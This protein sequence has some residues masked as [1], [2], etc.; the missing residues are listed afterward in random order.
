ML[1]DI[2]HVKAF[3]NH[4]LPQHRKLM[5]NR[6]IG[7]DLARAYAILGMFL[8]NF[9]TVFGSHTNHLGLSGF[10]NLFNGNSSSLFVMLAGMGVS[11]M[12]NRNN[13]ALEDR[14]RIRGV[15]TR[16]SLF[17]IALGLA[18]FV[19]WPA[20]ILHFYGGYMHIAVLFI[21]LPKKYLL[22]ASLFAIVIFHVLL[23]VIPYEAGWNFDTFVY[24]DFWTISGFLRNTFYNGWNPIFPWVA[25][26]FLG[27]YLGKMKWADDK[28][29]MKVFLIG[30]AVY[31]IVSIIQYYAP[32]ITNDK[33]LLLYLTADYIP[34]FLPFMLG[35]A[36]FG[37]MIISIFVVVGR[38]F[39]ET[40]LAK[41]LAYTGQMTLTHYITHLTLGFFMLS[42]ITGRT[43]RY[44]MLADTPTS[45]II[46]LTFGMTYFL[47]SCMFSYYWAKKFKKGPLEMLMRKFSG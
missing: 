17:L 28:I 12:T 39:G 46:I 41:I 40:R 10:L 32:S 3:V 36:S 26:F 31:I 27:M 15:I 35:T 13:Y 2:T 34:P 19:W 20:D 4:R 45:P 23:A 21:F 9:N 7:F 30:L 47:C 25:F 22:S 8:V 14:K 29:P 16:R 44:D 24:N 33:F 5:E 1:P 37:L 42:L 43:L 38:R 11:L 6:I 18:F